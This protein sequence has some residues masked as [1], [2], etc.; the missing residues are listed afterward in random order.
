MIAFRMRLAT[1]LTAAAVLA[2]SFIPATAMPLAPAPMA[3]QVQ[4]SANPVTEVQYRRDHRDRRHFNDRR[5]YRQGYYNGHRG[6]RDYRRGY[7]QHNGYW[8]P[9]AAFGAAAIVGGAIA[10]QSH[11]SG[12]SHAQWCASRYRT[13][14]ASDNTYVSSPGVR[15]SCVR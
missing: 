4:S 8:F 12:G 7:R 9:L 2:S 1:A 11:A 5:H 10:S 13:Y 14:R 6:Y 15:R 3:S